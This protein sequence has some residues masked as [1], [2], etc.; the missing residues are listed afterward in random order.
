[1]NID[2]IK[3]YLNGAKTI[4][5]AKEYNTNQHNIIYFLNKNN[6]KL[7]GTTKYLINE[8]SFNE[9]D[10]PWKAYFLGFAIGDGHI[11]K[12]K[13]KNTWR[14]TI[15][16]KS[17]DSDLLYNFNSLLG[18]NKP[19][20]FRTRKRLDKLNK[21]SSLI[22]YNQIICN[23]LIKAGLGT[24][25]SFT[26]KFPKLEES[27]IRHLV[28]GLFDSDGCISKKPNKNQFA[29]DLI[30]SEDICSNVSKFLLKH[31]IANKLLCLTQY[32]KPLYRVKIYKKGNLIK[33][34][35]LLYDDVDI[36]LKR[37]KVI[38]DQI[39]VKSNI[40]ASMR[41]EL[42]PNSKL[43]K[44]Q[45]KEIKS[46]LSSVSVKDI[47]KKFNVSLCAIYDIKNKQSWKW[48]EANS[49][50]KGGNSKLKESEVVFIKLN[51]HLKTIEL[52]KKFNI[53]PGT[54]RSIKRGDT[55]SHV[56]KKE[57]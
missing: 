27:L 51:T 52:S 46:L 29:F 4:D 13:G 33:L 56:Q 11:Y 44:D 3:K 7:K 41:G 39:T 24:K 49:G 15:E 37:K 47:A 16:L 40:R 48:V 22:I 54:V 28:R 12:P 42:N 50:E 43:M 32:S 10:S 57:V 1:M 34:R 5:L 9:I 17:S 38:F 18:Y 53:S 45:V 55:W 2:I 20:I 6:I 36:F 35:D 30:G 8:N 19:L 26:A 14:F 31:D 25:K 21:S 23:N